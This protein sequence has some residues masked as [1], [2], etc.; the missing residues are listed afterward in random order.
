M[1]IKILSL[2]SCLALA[3][4]GLAAFATGGAGGGPSARRPATSAGVTAFIGA[5]IID[6]GGKPAVENASMIVRDGR[7][8]AA[9]P[10]SEVKPPAGA[11]TINLT[12]KFVI[13]G[14]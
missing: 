4:A 11:R 14:L 10:A 2:G 9:G 6:G 3:C 13:P 5:R 8:E 1:S 12:G 7:I